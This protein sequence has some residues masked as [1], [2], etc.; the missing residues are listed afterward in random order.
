MEALGRDNGILRFP[1]YA[2]DDKVE[3]VV[4]NQTVVS[5]WN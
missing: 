4:M 1:L 2:R 3:S 5:L